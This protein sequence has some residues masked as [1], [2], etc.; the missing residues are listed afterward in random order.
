MQSNTKKNQPTTNPSCVN[1]H[2]HELLYTIFDT[3]SKPEDAD[4]E[5]ELEIKVDKTGNVTDLELVPTSKT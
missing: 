4:S 1:N 2:L 5:I 3:Q